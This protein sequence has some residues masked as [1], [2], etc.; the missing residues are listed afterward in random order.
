MPILT[1][2][3]LLQSQWV[4][5]IAPTYSLSRRTEYVFTLH[6]SMAQ[7]HLLTKP[8]RY[9][10]LHFLDRRGSLSLRLRHRTATTALTCEQKPYPV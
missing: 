9:V 5:D 2:E 4:S 8:I 6:Q 7:N 1:P 10:T 3:Y